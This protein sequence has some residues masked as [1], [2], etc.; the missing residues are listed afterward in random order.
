MCG[1]TD[2]SDLDNVCAVPAI[3]ITVRCLVGRFR[4]V[5]ELVQVDVLVALVSG[6][7]HLH[8]VGHGGIEAAPENFEF[9]CAAVVN[10]STKV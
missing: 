3:K 5:L 10:K 1:A 8:V 2:V 9:F 6:L 7:L 4:S